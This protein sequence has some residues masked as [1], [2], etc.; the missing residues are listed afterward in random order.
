[1]KPIVAGVAGTILLAGTLFVGAVISDK[2]L[3]DAKG[4]SKETA[5][6]TKIPTTAA[7]QSV[8]YAPP[9]IEEVPDGPMKEAILYGYELVNNTHVAA[10]EYVGNQLS[11]TS[12]HAGAGYDEQ[13]SSLVG[14]MA[15]YPQYIARSGDI[16][17]I[18]ERIN[19]CMVR[20]M[21]GKKFDTN[22]KELEAMVSYLAYISEGVPIGA[23]REWVGTSTMK[24][25]PIPDVTNGEEVY[26][27]SCMTC[28]AADGSGTGAN[29]GPALWG[30][31]SFNDGAGMARMS[32]MTGYIK[33]NMPVGAAGTL[34]DQNAADLAAF[35]LSQDRPEWKNHDK[36]W[37][38]GE[39][40]NDIMNKE[41]R[42]Q[43]K[44]G[45]INWEQVLS[46]N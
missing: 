6:Q 7:A 3:G 35:I 1:M 45:T 16:V 42:E 33:H 8:V 25:I 11:C 19:G 39:R 31:N 24:N 12:C 14:V 26:A 46:A 10:E 43:V 38:K 20:S 34:T 32:K 28:H 13:V 21:N 15:N 40:P 9:S 17:T 4:E 37:P 36:D 18:E 44:N 41:K 5:V 22:S 23:D 27:Q 30:K 2:I 29:T